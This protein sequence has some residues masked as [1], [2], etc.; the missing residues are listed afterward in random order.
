MKGMRSL[1]EQSLINV[2]APKF[3]D[4]ALAA[5]AQEVGNALA[6][7]FYVI[8]SPINYSAEKFKIRHVANLK[9][10]EDDIQSK[11]KEIPEENLVDP[12]LNIVG[13][14]LEA[15]KFHI[16]EEEIRNLFAKLIASSM[17]KENA[18]LIHPSFV[19]IIK[20]MSSLDAI[21][22]KLIISEKNN[23]VV[24]YSIQQYEEDSGT[25][26]A[27][28]IVFLSN[29][30]CQDMKL[31]STSLTNLSRLGLINIDFTRSFT[32]K[33]QYDIF[34]ETSEHFNLQNLKD[35]NRIFDFIK[36]TGI[37]MP[38]PLGYSFIEI[39]GD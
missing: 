18:S 6:N 24:S 33:S 36:N 25:K 9:K 17:N 12:P 14:A 8:F 10:Y 31:I 23:P 4:N 22:L 3:L 21:N 28:D 16:E 30:D 27:Y 15:S 34:D 11:L 13:P 29:P 5:P 38:T 35:E 37:I 2:V 20:Q 1:S 7:I 19:E 32:D 39:C 26:P